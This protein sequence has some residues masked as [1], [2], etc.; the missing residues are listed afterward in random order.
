MTEER[1]HKTDIPGKFAFDVGLTFVASI[2]SVVLGFLVSILLG[3]Y[4][5]ASDLGIFKMASVVYSI[6]VLVVTFG[7]PATVTKF[8]AESKNDRQRM[9]VVASSGLITSCV[10]GL[11]SIP[12]FFVM[13]KY[14]ETAFGIDGLASLLKILAFAFPF[15]LTG[16][17]LLGVLNGLREMRKFALATIL[18]SLLMLVLSVAMILSGFGVEGVVFSMVAASS[19]GC[20]YLIVVCRRHFTLTLGEYRNAAGQILRF[21]SRIVGANAVNL[22]N[23][24]GDLLL[25]GIFMTT[26]D[27][28]IYGV[29]IGL[30]KFMWLFPQAVQTITYPAITEQW[31]KHDTNAIGRLIDKSTKY[32]ALLLVPIGLAVGLYAKE[33]I[34]F[35][36]G[37]GFDDSV[38]P[39]QILLA[40]VVV[41]GVMQRP[42]GSVLFSLG[43]PGLNLRIFASAA[44]V[45][46]VLNILL[47]GA[48]GVIGAAVAVST[49]YILITILVL[50]FVWRVTGTTVDLSWFARVWLLACISVAG[51]GFLWYLNLSELSIAL[52]ASVT[53]AVWFGLTSREERGHFWKSSKETISSLFSLNVNRTRPDD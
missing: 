19:G 22:V 4:L 24:Q 6:A 1:V 2:I 47:I 14:L 53:A 46:I 30:A 34:S 45:N 26:S 27:V 15:S 8:V 7:I 44:I 25:I 12:V 32:T 23:Y 50:L 42:I 13:A 43:L 31:S 40:G 49:T 20:L 28:G 39:L 36:M 37:A 51:F 10:F 17:V 3:R 38:L 11:M 16:G 18:Q 52:A 29:A 5:G 33:I 35:I 21:G 41:N 48:F 9:N